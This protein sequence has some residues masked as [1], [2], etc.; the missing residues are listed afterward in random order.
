MEAWLNRRCPLLNGVIHADGRVITIR[1]KYHTAR[2]DLAATQCRYHLEQ[3]GATSIQDILAHGKL[4]W[5]KVYATRETTKTDDARNL[6]AYSGCDDWEGTGFVALARADSDQLIWI[7]YFEDSEPFVALQLT[8]A[9]VQAVSEEG[10]I[11]SF[12]IETPEDATVQ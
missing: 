11:W 4:Q 10:N 1:V 12:P 5:T 9:S 7:A 6:R 3:T 2:Q 8:P